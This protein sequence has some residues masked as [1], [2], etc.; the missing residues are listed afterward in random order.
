[1]LGVAAQERVPLL[2]AL[3]SPNLPPLPLGLL[4]G[5]TSLHVA[6]G[7][8]CDPLTVRVPPG[9]ICGCHGVGTLL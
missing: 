9:M 8:Q 7:E 4:R 1:M 3:L 6:L 2:A 5:A